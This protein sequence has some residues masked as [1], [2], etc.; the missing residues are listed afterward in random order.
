MDGRHDD[1]GWDAAGSPVGAHAL[2]AACCTPEGYAH[3]RGVAQQAARLARATAIPR[4]ARA[5]LLSAAWL[6]W[7]G[8]GITGT[9]GGLEGPQAARAAGHDA[10]AR[11]LAWAG[12]GRDLVPDV[13][14]AARFPLPD[15]SD[16]QALILL[17]I[18]LVTTDRAGAPAP[19]AAVLRGLSDVHGPA[20]PR[21]AVFIRLVADLADLPE[22][23]ELIA[24][25]SPTQA[26]AGG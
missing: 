21:V 6:T 10:L 14:L 19:P 15:G 16:A 24:S 12:G 3:V 23:R 22:A 25:V 11:V 13:D 1:P 2:A 17:D 8:P 7:A 5:M 20:D 18:A 4:D 26:P 9:G